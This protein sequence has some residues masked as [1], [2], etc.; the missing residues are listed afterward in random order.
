M[1]FVPFRQNT[2]KVA[3]EETILS[4][5]IIV[6]IAIGLLYLRISNTFH[7]PE[8]WGEDVDFYYEPY[9]HGLGVFGRLIA[10]Y[11]LFV[12]SGIGY[13]TSFFD[14]VYVAAIFCYVAI[15]VVALTVWIVTSPRLMLPYKPVLA[16]AIVLVPMGHEELGNTANT[17]WILPIG[18]FA[19]LLMRPA[20]SRMIWLAEALFVAVMSLSGPFSIFLAPLYGVFGYYARSGSDRTRLLLLG[21][22][23][24]LGAVCQFAIIALHGGLSAPGNIVP[25]DWTLWLNLPF[26]RIATDFGP[27]S[28]IFVGRT[29]FVV[30]LICLAVAIGVAFRPPYRLQKFA[31]LYFSSAIVIGGLFKFRESLGTQATATRYFYAGSVLLFWFFALTFHNQR[32]RVGAYIVLIGSMLSMIPAVFDT[33]TSKENLHWYYWAAHAESGVPILIPATPPG[34]Y[35]DLPANPHGPLASYRNVLGQPIT[36]LGL[37]NKAFCDGTLSTVSLLPDV[38]FASTGLGAAPSRVWLASGTVSGA[39]QGKP[40]DLIAL[41]DDRGTVVGFGFPDYPADLRWITADEKVLQWRAIFTSPGGFKLQAHAISKDV[42]A[43]CSLTGSPNVPGSDEKLITPEFVMAAPILPRTEIV[44]QFTASPTVQSLSLALVTW[45]HNPSPYK[46]NWRL[47]AR[48]ANMS[49][50]EIGAGVIEADSIADWQNVELPFSHA[51]P[52]SADLV[53]LSIST[54]LKE[55]PA[56]PLGVPF[57]RVPDEQA[58][59][60]ALING[61]EAGRGVRV[62]LTSI[63]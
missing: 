43:S 8:L 40:V 17:Q 58:T 60:P 23:C 30:A 11:L 55:P 49:F 51:R 12:Q 41:T 36:S 39:R 33:P 37:S 59:V 26:A 10:G 18:A 1:S 52:A 21:A 13:L 56:F 53:R 54:D 32:W 63:Y 44:Q 16:M 7:H 2:D 57:F 4:R 34:F 29:G 50:Q 47:D 42:A 14:P 48:S 3:F 19:F 38:H 24:S 5:I 35:L 28:S 25:Y 22:V 31:I 15:L 27:L 6:G 9:T 20:S 62:G 46:V 61:V 45:G